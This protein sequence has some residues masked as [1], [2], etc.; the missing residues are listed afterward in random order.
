[1]GKT[2]A[3]KPNYITDDF[4]GIEFSRWW[5][6]L[7]HNVVLT[8]YG[9]RSDPANIAL[10]CHDCNEVLASHDNPGVKEVGNVPKYKLLRTVGHHYWIETATDRI[11]VSDDSGD[12]PDSTDDGVLYLDERA[13]FPLLALLDMECILRVLPVKGYS[14]PLK[15][16]NND[17]SSTPA[18]FQEAMYVLELVRE[19]GKGNRLEEARQALIPPQAK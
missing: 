11:V 1:M 13:L 19:R 10:E 6:H 12:D 14:I 15:L 2:N 5:D 18:D 16:P 3:P 7:E 9:R 4:N 8:W 17:R